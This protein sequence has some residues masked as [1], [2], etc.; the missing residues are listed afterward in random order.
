MDPLVSIIIPTRN[1]ASTLPTCLSS[2]RRQTY[3]ALEVIVVDNYSKDQTRRIAEEHGAKVYLKGPERSSQKNYGAKMAKGEYLYFI[4]ADFILHPNVIEECIELVRKGHDAV[5][6]WNISDPRI[7]V[8]SKARYYERLSYYGSGLYE[9]A[10]F[11]HRDLFWRIK[12]FDESLYALEDYDL[13]L[14]LLKAGARI[15]RT[16]KTY[17]IHIG[18]PKDLRE[19]TTKAIYYAKSIRRYVRK[20]ARERAIVAQ[21]LPIR[22]TFLTPKTIRMLTREWPPA[23]V[24]IPTMKLIQAIAVLMAR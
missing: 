10:R 4:D 5:I 15:A 22:P 3:K 11:I 14:R 17:E 12:G 24:L 18:E 1:S 9:A 6:V 2:V 20:H 23:L 13:H 7:S 21:T 8:W 19:L 16:R